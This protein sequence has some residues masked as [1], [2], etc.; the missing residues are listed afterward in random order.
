MVFWKK[1]GNWFKQYFKEMK[2]GRFCEI[3]RNHKYNRNKTNYKFNSKF[4]LIKQYEYEDKKF[5]WIFATNLNFKSAKKY[6]RRYRQ[7]HYFGDMFLA[8]LY[9]SNCG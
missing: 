8:V 4:V 2:D 9:L 5:D 7:L 1:S 6:V 3:I